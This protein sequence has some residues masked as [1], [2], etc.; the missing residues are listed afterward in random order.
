[1]GGGGTAWP[2]TTLWG[3]PRG[4]SRSRAEP[5]CS[6][7]GGA[8]GAGGCGLQGLEVQATASG[9]HSPWATVT[10]R[11]IGQGGGLR[12]PL[13]GG[14]TRKARGQDD[15]QSEAK[16]QQRGGRRGREATGARGVRGEEQGRVWG[17]P[18][19]S[20]DVPS[21]VASLPPARS[22]AGSSPAENPAL[23]LAA[24]TPCPHL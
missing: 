1:M 2:G 18:P 7:C 21:P 16:E 4:S 20:P 17:L 15:G 10:V 8:G 12:C 5:D 11:P 9:A 24:Q 22:P 14:R 13:P 3:L 19:T 23:I 6:L